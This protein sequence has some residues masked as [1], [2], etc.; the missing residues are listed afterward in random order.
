MDS[1]ERRKL[2][3]ELVAIVARLDAASDG[4]A[5][6]ASGGGCGDLSK[7][8]GHCGGRGRVLVTGVAAATLAKVRS[9]IESGDT[10]YVVAGVDCKRFGCTGQALSNRLAKLAAAGLLS[11]E[12]H[13]VEKRYTPTKGGGDGSHN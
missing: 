5:A 13:G 3:A 6:A 1:V 12:R 4:G 8:C 7:V 10:A 9:L 2:R 11:A